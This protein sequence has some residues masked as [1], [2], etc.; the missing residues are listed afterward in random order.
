MERMSGMR[1]REYGDFLK[2][3]RLV[4]SKKMNDYLKRAVVVFA[5]LL[6]LVF[7]GFAE[8][9][10]YAVTNRINVNMR[11]KPESKSGLIMQIKTRGTKLTVLSAVSDSKGT[12][13]LQVETQLGKKG[14]IQATYLTRTD[15]KPVVKTDGRYATW[16]DAYNDFILGGKYKNW[17]GPD[18]FD[19][20]W[21]E[22][23]NPPK[24]GLYD[25]DRNGIPELLAGG[26]EAMASNCY[27]VFTFVNGMVQFCGNAG[28]ESSDL[29]VIPDCEYVG[30]FC[31]DG[32]QD[33]YTTVYYELVDA[34]IAEHPV[35][36]WQHQ[37]IP[38]GEDYI[39]TPGDPIRL[40][41]DERLF[42]ATFAHHVSK[43]LQYTKVQIQR[44]GWENFLSGPF[45]TDVYVETWVWPDFRM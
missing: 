31:H 22:P 5:A 42:Q 34:R 43:L 14:Y 4:G 15:G 20:I 44:M 6:L 3:I 30:V 25:I 11:S 35:R 37:W 8:N 1:Q 29:F 45:F 17:K 24:F 26:N 40:T 13:W 32:K 41:G 12:E 9:P 23:D 39:N 18:S 33:I 27:H 7:S 21:E 38:K 16:S 2:R 36:E 10:Y 19:N 28:F